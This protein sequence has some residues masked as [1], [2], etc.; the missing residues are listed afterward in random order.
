MKFSTKILDEELQ[1][2]KK[3]FRHAHSFVLFLDISVKSIDLDTSYVVGLCR[4]LGIRHVAFRNVSFDAQNWL[5]FKNVMLKCIKQYSSG[6]LCSSF[7]RHKSYEA[8]S[9]GVSFVI[10]ER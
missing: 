4:N 7:L 6:K 9:S 5:V 2:N 1:N 8:Y 10:L 3:F